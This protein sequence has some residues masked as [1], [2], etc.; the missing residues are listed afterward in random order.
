MARTPSRA[1]DRVARDDYDR[2]S[3]LNIDA[4]SVD[5]RMTTAGG[6][7]GSGGRGGGGGGGGA[8]R[9]RRP[10]PEPQGFDDPE[11]EGFGFDPASPPS[12]P[13]VVKRPS[14]TRVPAAA[15]A[16]T[17][18]ARH[19]VPEQL[20]RG[21]GGG[22]GGGGATGSPRMS[23][24]ISG[25]MREAAGAA[26]AGAAV[27]SPSRRGTDPEEVMR[28]MASSSLPGHGGSTSGSTGGSR[29]A[30][31]V[32]PARTTAGASA[33]VAVAA[34]PAPGTPRGDPHDRD[35]REYVIDEELGEFPPGW[36]QRTTPTGAVYFVDHIHRT[37]TFEDPRLAD[38]AL[39]MQQAI[40]H[41]AKLP[42]YKRD[43][44][45]K[46][47]KLHDLFR[48]TSREKEKALDQQQP[49]PPRP[50]SNPGGGGG[51]SNTAPKVDI[52]VSRDTIFEDSYMIL[53]KL[54]PVVPT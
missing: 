27:P 31:P 45:R 52:A 44:R 9:A 37:T 21:T 18:S 53:M 5:T 12:K 46:L 47:L 14:A 24:S 6:G 29:A 7:G 16:A 19:R 30:P 54:R 40:K 42:Q 17:P 38:R 25:I 48:H 32:R 50:P 33:A 36:E 15:A 41:E 11:L 4:I 51:G 35:W 3:L 43:L 2:R 23:R 20:P 49:P 10:E 34:L 8:R 28:R 1:N 39:R 13:K 22:G 26:G